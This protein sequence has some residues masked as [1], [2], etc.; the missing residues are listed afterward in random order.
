MQPLKDYCVKH[1]VIC[2]AYE[3]GSDQS[4]RF[5]SYVEEK[6]HS[7]SLITPKNSWSQNS[8]RLMKI[9]SHC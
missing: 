5:H 7:F 4:N 2:V 6:L 1:T 8:A 3:Y 9:L